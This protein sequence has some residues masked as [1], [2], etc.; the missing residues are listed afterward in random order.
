[1]ILINFVCSIL[2]DLEK[3]V[4]KHVTVYDSNPCLFAGVKGTDAMKQKINQF[5]RGN[6]KKSMT[7]T[8]LFKANSSK[9]TATQQILLKKGNLFLYVDEVIKNKTSKNKKKRILKGT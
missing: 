6:R 9:T 2:D 8:I 4:L 3:Y 1:M 7:A 5:Y